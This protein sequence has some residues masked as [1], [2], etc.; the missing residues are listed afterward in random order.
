MEYVSCT[1]VHDNIGLRHMHLPEQETEEK[2]YSEKIVLFVM[3]ITKEWLM[4][5]C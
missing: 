5:K 4:L 2:L 3:K 1:A